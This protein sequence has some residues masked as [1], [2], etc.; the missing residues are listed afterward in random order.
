MHLW[1]FF[2]LL[3]L[4][5]NATSIVNACTWSHLKL[6]NTIPP[7]PQWQTAPLLRWCDTASL[8]YYKGKNK[9]QDHHF[10]RSQSSR[11]RQRWM[12][13]GFGKHPLLSNPRQKPATKWNS[14]CVM[15]WRLAASTCACVCVSPPDCVPHST[16][17]TAKR[18]D[19][20]HGRDV[21]VFYPLPAADRV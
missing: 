17:M 21:V 16:G 19:V 1:H 2:Y 10:R 5:P 13:A 12:H 8:M 15:R 6:T 18:S 7:Q 14:I 20:V 3:V 11:W 9:S 4:K